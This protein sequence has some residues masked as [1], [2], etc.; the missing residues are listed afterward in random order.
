MSEF[1][2]WCL[3]AAAFVLSLPAGVVGGFFLV[4]L[5]VSR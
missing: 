5:A 2:R 4:A 1:A 3:V